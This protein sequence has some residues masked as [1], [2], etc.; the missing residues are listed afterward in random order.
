M[1]VQHVQWPYV[2]ALKE[3]VVSTGRGLLWF[4]PVDNTRS[5]GVFRDPVL[6]QLIKGLEA[7]VEARDHVHRL[8]PF[9]WMALYDKLQV[10]NCEFSNV[11]SV[12]YILLCKSH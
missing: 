3:G 6:N 2:V 4:Y 8:V 7:T 1:R 12:C 5:C 11:T 10:E 9:S